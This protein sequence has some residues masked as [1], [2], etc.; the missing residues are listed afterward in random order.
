MCCTLNCVLHCALFDFHSIQTIYI[1]YVE[2]HTLSDSFFNTWCNFWHLLGTDFNK[3]CSEAATHTHLHTQTQI[4]TH[5]LAFAAF[6]HDSWKLCASCPLR[7]TQRL[8]KRMHTNENGNKERWEVNFF[9]F[10]FW[11][12]QEQPE[13]CCNAHPVKYAS[14]CSSNFHMA[15]M[16]FQWNSGRLW[17]TCASLFM[18][19]A[20]CVSLSCLKCRLKS[21]IHIVFILSLENEGTTP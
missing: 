17:I 2:C 14:T 19:P 1:I 21:Y 10:C 13:A 12:F 18:S 9:R 3:A 16:C 11:S 5:N 7:V 20:L 4:Y 8:E 6:M 15:K